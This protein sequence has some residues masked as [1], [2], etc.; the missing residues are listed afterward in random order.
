MNI[1]CY[2]WKHKLMKTHCFVC[3]EPRSLT[4]EH[5]IPQ[6][7][8]GRLKAKLY[9][10]ECNEEFGNSIDDEISKQFA[11]IGTLLNIKRERSKAQPYEVNELKSGTTFLLDGKSMKRKSPV[12]KV[13]SKDGNKLDFA[14]VTA[15]SEKELKRICT[16]IQKRYNIPGD[17]KTFQ[18][19]HEGPTEAERIMMIDNALLRRAVSKIAYGFTCIK[20]P[21]SV[22]FSSAFEAV[23]KYINASDKPALACANYVHTKFMTDYVRPIHK[24]HVAL[25]RNRGLLVGYVSLFGI[26]RFTVLLAENFKSELEWPDLDY[27]FD[28]VRRE[29]V[30]GNENFRVPQLT[31]E[32]IL[33]PRQSK[34]FI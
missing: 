4:V 17:M 12:V 31:E 7:I 28:P 24:I 18:D 14:D 32:N 33:H 11:W 6:A 15:R 5:V 27:T 29:Q 34:E 8:G 1:N 21:E 23:R 20:L 19:V 3:T 30:V 2:A 9:C 25:N 26:Y 22:I 16:S 10:K 13:V